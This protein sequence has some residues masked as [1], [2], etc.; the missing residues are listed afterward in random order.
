MP[1][2]SHI[3]EEIPGEQAHLDHTSSALCLL[4]VV[5]VLVEEGDHIL[6]EGGHNPV[7]PHLAAAAAAVR[8]ATVADPGT[9]AAPVPDPDPVR[10]EDQVPVAL[11][12]AAIVVVPAVVPP[13][14]AEE[15]ARV[16]P[17]GHILK[18]HLPAEV[19]DEEDR[20]PLPV[21]VP[22]PVRVLLGA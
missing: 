6:A 16:D 2:C 1:N 4:R 12:E 18:A 5:P 15:G 21:L 22:V 20:K 9:T 14:T 3:S 17:Y 8:H 13:L 10:A 11:L 19:A 7:P